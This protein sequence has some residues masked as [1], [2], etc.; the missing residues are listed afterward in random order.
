MN[1][2]NSKNLDKGNVPKDILTLRKIFDSLGIEEYEKNTLNF[3][4]EF[5]NTYITDLLN[6]AK[7]NMLLANRN[8]INI[9]DIKLAVKTKQNILYKNKLNVDDLKSLAY[10][11]N[12]IELPNIPDSPNVLMPP[13]EN[14]LLK[15]NF[16]VYSDNLYQFYHNNEHLNEENTILK[17]EIP[18]LG[19]KRKDEKLGDNKK[20]LGNPQ[21]KKRKLS[22]TQAFKSSK[23][24]EENAKKEKNK[25]K[26]E[27]DFNEKGDNNDI[28]EGADP[29]FENIDNISNLNEDIEMKRDDNL[30]S[31][32]QSSEKFE[33]IHNDDDE[34]D[35]NEDDFKY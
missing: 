8:K 20:S 15:N 24:K 23:E 2:L 6:D 22:L 16:Q 30:T 3:M 21:R 25:I 9:E 27:N 11:V 34:G 13:F 18:M 1:I 33:S 32:K 35:L 10:S 19:F 29:I 4:S 17:T 14:S 5:L 26:I 28:D 12:R 7:K 31:H